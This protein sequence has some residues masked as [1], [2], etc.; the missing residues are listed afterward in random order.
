MVLIRHIMALSG[1]MLGALALF[2]GMQHLIA[3]DES[4]R[5]A[6]PEH[7]IIDFVRIKHEQRAPEP[8]KR[9]IHQ[10][11]PKPMPPLQAP[12]LNTLA[13]QTPSPIPVLPQ[14]PAMQTHTG[15][16]QGPKL[17]MAAMQG[18]SELAPLVRINP[19]YPPHARR[20]GIQGYVKAELVV[21]TEGKVKSIEIIESEPAGEFDRAVRRSLIRW[22][23]KPKTEAGKAMEYSGVVTIRFNLQA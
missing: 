1:G 7:T 14:M 17:S 12:A 3:P 9:E 18:D 8:K 22:K 21:D 6:I 10:N 2:W 11:K 13:A 23:F 16:T 15:F 4:I 20:L 5:K 19:Q